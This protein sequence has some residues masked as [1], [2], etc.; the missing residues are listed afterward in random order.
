MVCE[1][2]GF[3]GH[4]EGADLDITG[5]GRA[6]RSTIYDK[7]PVGVARR[8]QARGV[9]T[10]ILAGILGPGKRFAREEQLA[11]YGGAAPLE[12][13]SAGGVRHRLNR[14]G[15]RRLNSILYR[16]VLTQ[17]RRSEEGKT[18]LERRMSEGKTRREAVRALKRY[19][20]RAI[21]RLWQKCLAQQASQRMPAAA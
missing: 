8:A 13:S 17:S 11:A 6:D 10:I 20:A 7:A 18:Y 16:I 12:A 1:V 19:I 21:W 14:S 15:N 3:D 9:P 2:L 4:L 5:E